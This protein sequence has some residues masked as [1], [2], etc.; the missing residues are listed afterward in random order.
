MTKNR[1]LAGM[2]A[3]SLG[4]WLA[5][6]PNPASAQ[7]QASKSAGKPSAQRAAAMPAAQAEGDYRVG[8]GDSIQ[9]SVWKEPEASTI[10]VVRPDGKISLPLVNDLE[11]SGKTPMEI[12]EILA[13]KLSPF[14]KDPNVTVTVKEIHSHKVYVLGQVNKAGSYQIVQPTTILQM[15][16]DA[17]GLQP[18][19]KAKSIY[20]LRTENGQQRKLSFNYKDVVQ[21]KKIE[22]NIFVQPGDTIVVP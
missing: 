22:Q 11:V 10:V 21:G 1:I 9:V 2:A 3:A 7:P 17:G 6:G 5:L 16:T 8:L 15:L 20:V 12:Q 14:I 19:A 13:A 18:Y 4:A